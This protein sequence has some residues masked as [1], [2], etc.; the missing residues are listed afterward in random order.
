MLIRIIL[1]EFYL[2]GFLLAIKPSLKFGTFIPKENFEKKQIYQQFLQQAL[3][4]FDHEEHYKVELITKT[5]SCETTE[6]SE[7]TAKLIHLEHVDV[8]FG[9]HCSQ[10]GCRRVLDYNSKFIIAYKCENTDFTGAHHFVNVQPLIKQEPVLLADAFGRILQQFKWKYLGI[11][12]SM[13]LKMAHDITAEILKD[14]GFVVSSFP[15]ESDG[16]YYKRLMGRVKKKAR[17][18]LSVQGGSQKL[19]LTTKESIV[20]NSNFSGP[21]CKNSNI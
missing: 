7:E 17:G 14:R 5:T 15:T 8:I 16:K 3:S 13:K 18:T 11:V 6:L 1:C 20:F 2:A 21:H 19:Q 9:P 12:Y 4:I 10:D